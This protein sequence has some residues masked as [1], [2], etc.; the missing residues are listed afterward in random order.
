MKLKAKTLEMLSRCLIDPEVLQ[1]F[2]ATD[3]TTEQIEALREEI[4]DKLIKEGLAQDD[5]PN[6]YGLFL[7]SLI[8]DLGH[9][10]P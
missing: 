3:L 6:K 8:D 10:L 9:Y 4:C 1:R 5:E 7:E 2:T